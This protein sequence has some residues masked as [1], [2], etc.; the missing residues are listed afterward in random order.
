MVTAMLGFAIAA[1]IIVTVSVVTPLVIIYAKPPSPA[2]APGPSFPTPATA[3]TPPTPPTPPNPPPPNPPDPPTPPPPQTTSQPLVPKFVPCKNSPNPPLPQVGYLP[4]CPTFIINY[5]TPNIRTTFSRKFTVYPPTPL[6]RGTPINFFIGFAMR[7]DPSYWIL[8]DLSLTA[9]NPNNPN[10]LIPTSLFAQNATLTIGTLQRTSAS[11]VTP[12]Y[13]TA[14]SQFCSSD[15]N[16]VTS[17]AFLD[18]CTNEFDGFYLPLS[19]QTGYSYTFNFTLLSDT[20]STPSATA[21]PTS[22]SSIL[23]IYAMP[24]MQN[25]SLKSSTACILQSTIGMRAYPFPPPPPPPPI[26]PP[27]PS[28]PTQ[29]E[30]WATTSQFGSGDGNWPGSTPG[31]NLCNSILKDQQIAK[32]KRTMAAAIPW[33]FVCS[34]YPNRNAWI[35]AII[36]SARGSNTLSTPCYE[37]EPIIHFGNTIQGP[38]CAGSSCIPI[39]ASI[40]ATTSTQT[41]YGTFLIIPY[42]GCGGDGKLKSQGPT[43]TSFDVFNSCDMVQNLVATCQ[44]VA[45]S[46]PHCAIA[47]IMAHNNWT[48]ALYQTAVNSMNVYPPAAGTL[49]N[50]GSNAS[51]VSST[52]PDGRFDY[53]TGENMHFD[54]AQTIPLWQSL[55]NYDAGNIAQLTGPTQIMVRYRKVSCAKNGFFDP[56][57]IPSAYA[58]GW[59]TAAPCVI[60]NPITGAYLKNDP[61][62][63]FCGNPNSVYCGSNASDCNNSPRLLSCCPYEYPKFVPSK[64]PSY[65]GY[66]DG[67]CCTNTTTPNCISPS[68]VQSNCSAGYV[69]MQNKTDCSRAQSSNCLYSIILSNIPQGGYCARLAQY[70]Q[71][72]DSCRNLPLGIVPNNTA[73]ILNL[74]C[75]TGAGGS[76]GITCPLGNYAKMQ[77]ASDCSDPNVSKLGTACLWSIQP[78]L[79]GAGFC[80]QIAASSY[81]TPIQ[82]QTLPNSF[83]CTAPNPL[84]PTV[85][86]CTGAFLPFNCTLYPGCC[87]YNLNDNCAQYTPATANCQQNVPGYTACPAPPGSTCAIP[88]PTPPPPPPP[89]SQLPYPPGY[90]QK[91]SATVN[92]PQLTLA[93]VQNCPYIVPINAAISWPDLVK[94]WNNY[95]GAVVDCPAAMI[96]AAGEASC[97]QN[98]C[99]NPANNGGFWQLT[100]SPGWSANFNYCFPGNLRATNVCCQMDVLRA[101]LWNNSTGNMGCFGNFHLPSD[102]P[103]NYIDPTHSGQGL[104]G[105]QPNFIGPFCQVGKHTCATNDPYCPGSPIW[106]SVESDNWGGGSN[107]YF[108]ST[109]STP[110]EQFPFPYYYYARMLNIFN[111]SCDCLTGNQNGCFCSQ[112]T[113]GVANRDL[114]N[115]YIQNIILPAV[116]YAKALCNSP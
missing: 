30:G 75:A 110:A 10:N 62:T 41:P 14:S 27:P 23:A 88:P 8:K 106:E 84:T 97:D 24:C 44:P 80:A 86:P 104:G 91:S 51:A 94:V 20:P 115:C 58:G 99:Q 28:P 9:A 47:N 37:I 90:I 70:P 87:F 52:T 109:P 12:W 19:L 1:S 114:E 72:P 100:S 76:S 34:T 79:T 92:L 48:P 101:H 31:L 25:P 42:E 98:G 29:W 16:F 38:G 64:P 5:S 66:A 113:P 57:S 6:T 4:P 49:T 43:A 107:W 50:F 53:C 74:V 26:P 56:S 63:A 65:Y 108:S 102:L 3:P 93:Q 112:F 77:N 71:S 46:D 2:P 82:C 54:M 68:N 40:G 83:L 36:D 32:N 15:Y 59:S 78:S 89:D 69:Y 61:N 35:Q 116:N 13:Q 18:G 67:L 95:G 111:S 60:Q 85:S 55:F 45:S 21:T 22:N 33:N 7:N 81:D 96:I 11:K 103:L 105:S 73:P 39:N 17:N